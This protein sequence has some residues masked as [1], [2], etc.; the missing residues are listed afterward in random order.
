VHLAFRLVQDPSAGERAL[1][2]AGVQ[3]RLG[4]AGVGFCPELAQ[5]GSLARDDVP[6]LAFSLQFMQ[7]LLEFFQPAGK[8][9]AGIKRGG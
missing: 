2:E 7:M 1:R 9:R 5:P 6:S 4:V 8:T 3:V